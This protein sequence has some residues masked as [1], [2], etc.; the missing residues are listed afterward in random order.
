[1]PR[2]PRPGPPLHA[3]LV[4]KQLREARGPWPGSRRVGAADTR[5][6]FDERYRLEVRRLDVPTS[7]EG[8]PAKLWVYRWTLARDGELV[9]TG[10]LTV[11]P[12]HQAR[13][14]RVARVGLALIAREYRA[15]GLYREVLRAVRQILGFPVESDPSMTEGAIGAWKALGAVTHERDDGGVVYRLNPAAPTLYHGT[16]PASARSLLARG[17]DPG[18]LQRRDS[19]Y[20]GLGF[21]AAETPTGARPYGKALLRLTLRPGARVLDATEGREFLGLLGLMRFGGGR[22]SY[23]PLVRTRFLARAEPRRGRAYAEQYWREVHEPD[24][25][26]FSASDTAKEVADWARDAGFDAVRWSPGEWVV[27]N[28]AAVQKLE[29]ASAARAA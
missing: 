27:V 22:P 12:G 1:V 23:W 18:R 5:D 8:R 28:A 11:Q 15:R 10:S 26:Y 13:G 17:V 16:D 2:A 21:Y 3:E 25:P 9:G 19:G 6:R 20:Y 24:S 7:H 14:R 29:R 4:E